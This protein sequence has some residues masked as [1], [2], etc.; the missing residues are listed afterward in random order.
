M[1]IILYLIFSHLIFL[2]SRNFFKKSFQDIF[3]TKSEETILMIIIQY[4]ITLIFTYIL[5]FIFVFLSIILIAS[6][7]KGKFKK[8]L[9]FI[10]FTIILLSSTMSYFN[11][12]KENLKWEKFNESNIYDYIKKNEIVFL[13]V[14]ADWCITCQVNKITTINSKKINRIFLENEIKLI[15]ADWTKRILKF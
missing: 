4:V 7:I 13:D 2:S 12:S 3:K 6:I 8:Q 11:K 10:S 1:T 15:Q 5:I 9:F 14:T